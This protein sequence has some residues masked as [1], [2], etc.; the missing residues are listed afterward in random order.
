MHGHISS[1]P[2]S[3]IA[4]CMGGLAPV[5]FYLLLSYPQSLCCSLCCHPP[6]PHHSLSSHSHSFTSWFHSSFEEEFWILFLPFQDIRDYAGS[7]YQPQYWCSLLTHGFFYTDVSVFLSCTCVA[8]IMQASSHRRLLGSSK[9]NR[10]SFGLLIPVPVNTCIL[11]GKQTE[12]VLAIG[13][14]GR[15]SWT[16]KT[17]GLLGRCLG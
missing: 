3:I 5:F 9:S 11:R 8:V 4:T 7:N 17:V 15:C 10:V 1:K 6:H 13:Q 12:L 14:P 16:C 2:A